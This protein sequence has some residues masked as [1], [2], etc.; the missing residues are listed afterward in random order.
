M[1]IN[2][3]QVGR[4][5]GILHKLMNM[6]EGAPSPSLATDIFPNIVLENDRPEWV[7]LAGGR[8]VNIT[9]YDPPAAGNYSS[10]IFR[11]PS[12]SGVLAV[13]QGVRFLLSG[14]ANVIMGYRTGAT[15]AGGDFH[16]LARDTRMA[17]A[18][19]ACFLNALTQAAAIGYVQYVVP[20][21][22]AAVVEE[23]QQAWVVSPGWDLYFY[24]DVQ[25]VGI[26]A[27]VSWRERALEPSETR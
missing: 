15:V 18:L 12:G 21:P 14:A 6:S 19:S 2:E 13:V 1:P 3:I 16:G 26:R 17:G 9:L 27:S 23:D 24:P 8:L 7:Y 10:V 25:N 20:F 5:N 11:N 4:F 22:A